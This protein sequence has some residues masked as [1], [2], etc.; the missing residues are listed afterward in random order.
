MVGIRLVLAEDVQMPEDGGAHEPART[1]AF[2]AW[3][4]GSALFFGLSF[5]A[6]GTVWGGLVYTLEIS[7][8]FRPRIHI[9]VFFG[10][11][12][13]GVIATVLLIALI[14]RL[15]LKKQISSQLS[16]ALGINFSAF[17][18]ILIGGLVATTWR[19][20]EVQ[21]FSP[22]EYVSSSFYQ[23][24]RETPKEFQFF[25]HAAA[26]KDCKPYIWSYSQMRFVHIRANTAVNVI[27][28]E[29]VRQCDIVRS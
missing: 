18:A 27:P 9:A 29:W 1:P 5:C 26:L 15:F 23:S 19:S 20:I 17:G 25:V 22:D 13:L 12:I 14:E 28:G 6:F 4:I 16:W 21:R 3:V 7:L 11:V 10:A 8:L 2:F 24:I